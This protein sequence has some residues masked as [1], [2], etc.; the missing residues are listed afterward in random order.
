MVGVHLQFSFLSAIPY[1]LG[2]AHMFRAFSALI[3]IAASS[4]VDAQAAPPAPRE[5]I[6]KNAAN[7]GIREWYSP[8]SQSIYLRHRTERW[9]LVSFLGSCPGVRSSAIGI[10]V[11][12]LGT[13]D[14]FST[15]VTNQGSC[16][17]KSIVRSPKP[18]MSHRG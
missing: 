12:T 4:A 13:F 8:N 5:T 2:A 14:R 18:D 9:Y 6:I 11:D 10:K 3:L 15:I 1:A 16:A 7:G 17:V